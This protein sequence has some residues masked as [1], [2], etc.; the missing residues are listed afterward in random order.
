MWLNKFAGPMKGAI[1]V[2]ICIDATG[3]MGDIMD[4][5]KAKAMLFLRK[6]PI[7]MECDCKEVD[8]LRVKVIAFRNY[9]ISEEPMKESRFFTVI[10]NSNN[11]SEEEKELQDY[12]SGIE[13][14]DDG[15]GSANALEAL[16]MAIKS[17]W[18]RAGQFR[19]HIIL[20]FTNTPTSELESCAD[21]TCYP[22]GLPGSLE[23]LREWWESD[24]FIERRRE[25]L[26]VFVP[27]A[28]PWGDMCNY[29]TR[30]FFCPLR[31]FDDEDIATISRFVRNG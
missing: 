10:T 21:K 23:E 14:K 30:S 18:N 15:S 31:D 5:V 11:C 9:E 20:M 2:V 25:R 8:Q 1:D 29:W 6:I 12:L 17:D 4:K 24:Q 7:E 28:E 3:S 13:S 16:A 26:F 19:R 27:E 22:A